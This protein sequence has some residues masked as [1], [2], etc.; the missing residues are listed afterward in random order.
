MDRADRYYVSRV[1]DPARAVPV[2]L[3]SF[4]LAAT[5]I[6]QTFVIVQGSTEGS[7]YIPSAVCIIDDKEYSMTPYLV[8][9][10]GRDGASVLSFPEV[11]GESKPDLVVS[12]GQRITIRLDEK[13]STLIT[14]LVDI[15]SDDLTVEPLE[16]VEE[17]T[18]EIS[19]DSPGTK[20]LQAFVT[21]D[22]GRKVSYTLLLEI[23]NSEDPSEDYDDYLR[24]TNNLEDS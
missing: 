1:T 4:A 7:S 23:D 20:S 12:D 21:F 8:G 15:D 2:L 22:D 11:A 6:T 9:D 16:N 18:F 24:P 3:L 13:P 17:N 19:S 5:F 10:K 14:A